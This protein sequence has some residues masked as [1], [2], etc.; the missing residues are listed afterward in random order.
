MFTKSLC[1]PYVTRLWFY[2]EP[3]SL[4]KFATFVEK[5]MKIFFYVFISLIAS[6]SYN[7][8]LDASV[9]TWVTDSNKEEIEKEIDS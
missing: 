3:Y 2:H 9:F 8:L 6:C 4:E 5:W 7:F 1:H